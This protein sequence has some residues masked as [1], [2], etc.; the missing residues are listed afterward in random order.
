MPMGTAS[1]QQQLMTN[2]IG[3][4]SSPTGNVANYTS[5]TNGDH[6]SH[7]DDN[8]AAH[9]DASPTRPTSRGV[10][11]VTSSQGRPSTSGGQTASTSIGTNTGSSSMDLVTIQQRPGSNGTE[12]NA[13]P[14]MRHGFAEAYS[15]EEYL[16]MLEQVHRFSQHDLS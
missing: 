6:R 1:R 15:S 16:T 14:A 4:S 8:R 12:L 7:A 2:G 3:D 10:S 13:T 11:S 9:A 5:Y